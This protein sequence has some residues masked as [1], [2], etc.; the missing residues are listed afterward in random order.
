[1]AGAGN[2]RA[3]YTA[4]LLAVPAAMLFAAPAAADPGPAADPAPSVADQ[5]SVQAVQDEELL[6]PGLPMAVPDGAFGYLATRDATVWL[7]DRRPG[8]AVRGLPVAPN[9]K[10]SNDA[11]ADQLD[12][13]LRSAKASPGACVQIIVDPATSSGNLFDYGIF[14]VE[15]QYCP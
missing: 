13:E 8:D 12:R 14:A 1:M 2:R 10:A 9:L 4:M 15:K 11:L 3:I 6:P 7:A 5:P